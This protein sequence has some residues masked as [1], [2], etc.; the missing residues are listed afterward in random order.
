MK[1]LITGAGG[2]LGQDLQQALDGREVTALSRAELDVT[3]ARATLAAVAGHDVVINAAAYTKVDDAESHED[4]A[5]AINATGAENLARAVAAHGA[6]LVQVSTD[7][8]FDGTATTP[9]AEDA[10]PDPVSAYGRTKAEG[11]R[12]ARAANPDRTIIIRTAWLYGE[13]GP[14]FAKT[15]L[16]LAASHDTVSV[17]TDQVG[18]PTWTLDLAKQIVA[19]LETGATSGIHNGTASGEA[20]WYDFAR[21]IFSVCRL[22]PD[23]VRPTDSSQFVRPAPR[24]AYSVLGHD[25]W[26]RVGLNP[27]RDWR[28]ALDDAVAHGVLDQQ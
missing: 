21:A 22:D 16:R 27:L 8:V 6:I 18:Q 15:M 10:P 4:E 3:D 7:Y 13:H 19:L 14:N 20:S 24:P 5:Y 23:R 1:Y 9:Y 12:L 17:V 11:E 26:Q 28:L 25:S 2:M